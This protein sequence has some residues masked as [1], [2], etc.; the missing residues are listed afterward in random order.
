MREFDV[1]FDKNKTK[2]RKCNNSFGT[3][4][5]ENKKKLLDKSMVT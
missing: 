4:P 1:L 2:R 3:R 5:K